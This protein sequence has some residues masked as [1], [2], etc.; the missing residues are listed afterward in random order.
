MLSA[1]L[2]LLFPLHVFLDFGDGLAVVVGAGVDSIERVGQQKFVLADLGNIG[3]RGVLEGAQLGL[4]FGIGFDDELERFA[5]VVLAANVHVDVVVEFVV[6]GEEVFQHVMGLAGAL[7]R[8]GIAAHLF[9]LC[10]AIAGKL[11]VKL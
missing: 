7:G 4:E 9:K 10:H 1:A 6:Y 3:V 11:H 8:L 2:F 5:N